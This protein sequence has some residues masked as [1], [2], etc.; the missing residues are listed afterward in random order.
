MDDLD[1]IAIRFHYGGS[2]E[3]ANGQSVYVGGDIAESW[4]DVDKVSYFEIKGHLADHFKQ[5][6]AALLVE[7]REEYRGWTSHVDR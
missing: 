4:I 3:T 5:Y 6:S 7:A 1:K 2:F